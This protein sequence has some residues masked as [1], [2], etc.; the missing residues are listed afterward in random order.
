VRG[1]DVDTRVDASRM[2]TPCRGIVFEAHVVV[3]ERAAWIPLADVPGLERVP[4]VD[5]ALRLLSGARSGGRAGG[6]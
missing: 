2:P 6:R 4:L 3:T 1:G 5:I